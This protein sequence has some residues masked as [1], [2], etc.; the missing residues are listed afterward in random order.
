MTS[1][2]LIGATGNVGK[3]MLATDKKLYFKGTTRKDISNSDLLK[4]NPFDDR[5]TED[6]ISR[7]KP[8]AIMLL[9]AISGVEECLS[10]SL[11]SSI[12]IGLPYKIA[13]IAQKKKVK[14]IFTS[15]EYIYNGSIQGPKSDLA[16][17]ISADNNLYSLQ[18]YSAEKLVSSICENHLILRLPKMYSIHFQGNFLSNTI[19]KL[20]NS[21]MINVASDQFFSALSCADLCK[22]IHICISKNIQGTYNCG[23]PESK[24]RYQYTMEI[25]STMRNANVEINRTSLRQICADPSIPLDV[26]MNSQKLFKALGYTPLRLLEYLK[27]HR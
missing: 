20:K 15:T 26:S 24:S 7:I 11:S 6:L 23:G 22:I 13:K 5:E 2:I 25:L 17:N 14:L 19:I 8:K 27:L 1:C 16:C 4:L 12:N 21:K 3:A 9:S 10:N 18:K